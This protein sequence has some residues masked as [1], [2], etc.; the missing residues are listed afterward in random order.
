ML[1]HAS[2]SLFELARETLRARRKAREQ[3]QHLAASQSYDDEFSDQD[4]CEDTPDSPRID[5]H[6]K[7]KTEYSV[8][9]KHQRRQQRKLKHLQNI[10][11]ADND[12]THDPP[13]LHHRAW[14][15]KVEEVEDGAWRHS[16][17]SRQEWNSLV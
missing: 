14:S 7:P 5:H 8:I 9:T 15:A 6:F 1:G 2:C 4:D 13:V 12:A 16:L 10:S 11:P 3:Q 17:K